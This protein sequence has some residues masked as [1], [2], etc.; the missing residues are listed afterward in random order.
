MKTLDLR[1]YQ[2]WSTDGDAV[3]AIWN[4]AMGEQFPL[5]SRLWR[6][7]IDDD[8]HHDAEGIVVARDGEEVAGIA[9]ARVQKVPLGLQPM[10]ADKGWINSI[11]VAPAYQR[12]GIGTSLLARAKKWLVQQGV[13]EIGVG[14]DP[15]HF[16]PGLP[17][18]QPGARAF[19]DARGG[20]AVGAPC[21]DL[22]RD[23]R[24]FRIPAMIDRVMSRNLHFRITAATNRTVPALFEFL[25]ATFP[26]RWLYE[27]Q[28][29]VETE[30]SPQDI[31]VIMIGSRCVGFAHTFHGGSARIGPSIY[32]R[33]LLGTHY[34]G[35]GPIG[36]APD[37]RN[38]GLGFALLCESIE[39]L[40][41][42]GVQ[43]MA[44]DWTTLLKFYGAAGFEPWKEYQGYT[45]TV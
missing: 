3:L 44:I 29:R 32:W 42:L 45:L 28:M 6:Q 4:A 26:G 9:V 12:K 38:T 22:M 17:S 36:V 25:R 39:R 5:D 27:T 18:S 24:E 19:F 34:G 14:G 11:A 8:P 13:G 37:V 35:L 40:R 43:K 15:G 20:V 41:T 2:G 1:P 30:R 23:I 21:F 7:N 33:K 31:Q 10:A 16:F